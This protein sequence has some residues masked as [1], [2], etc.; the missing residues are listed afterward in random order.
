VIVGWRRDW[1]AVVVV[2]VG[3]DGEDKRVDLPVEVQW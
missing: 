1:T 2:V 3:E